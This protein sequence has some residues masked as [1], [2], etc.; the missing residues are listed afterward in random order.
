M[1]PKFKINDNREFQAQAYAFALTYVRQL[2]LQKL[3][4]LAQVLESEIIKRK[5]S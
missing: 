5:M 1:N 3:R 4:I 2:N